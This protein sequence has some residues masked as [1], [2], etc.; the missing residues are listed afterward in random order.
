MGD[1]KSIQ[2][3][4]V[5]RCSEVTAFLDLIRELKS[6]GYSDEFIA[7]ALGNLAMVYV[8]IYSP[9]IGFQE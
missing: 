9:S 8:A 5:D 4:K 7:S 3:G 6:D 2:G 1:L